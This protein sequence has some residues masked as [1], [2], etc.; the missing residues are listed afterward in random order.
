VRFKLRD[1]SYTDRF[2]KK[3]G[4]APVPVSSSRPEIFKKMTAP[5]V[6]VPSYYSNSYVREVKDQVLIHPVVFKIHE[7]LLLWDVEAGKFICKRVTCVRGERG[8]DVT[9]LSHGSV[10]CYLDGVIEELLKDY[11]M[12]TGEYSHMLLNVNNHLE[13]L[14][15]CPKKLILNYGLL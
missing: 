9:D 3:K 13:D 6:A 11:Q 12:F 2:K 15:F 4:A 1:G 7:H 5:L 14:N 10:T 8:F